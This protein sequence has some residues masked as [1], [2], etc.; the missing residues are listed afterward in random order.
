MLIQ[1]KIVALRDP[2]LIIS[3]ERENNSWSNAAPEIILAQIAA[4]LHQ[5][6]NLMKIIDFEKVGEI[7]RNHVFYFSFWCNFMAIWSGIISG[8]ALDQDF[9]SLSNKI[10]R[11]GFHDATILVLQ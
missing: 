4:K 3:F 5:N 11:F 10:V 9:F 2:N 6:E 1:T 8:P 7:L